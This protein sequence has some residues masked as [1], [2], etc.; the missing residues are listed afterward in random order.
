MRRYFATLLLMGLACY[1]DYSLYG[2]RAQS[3]G[4]VAC[5]PPRLNQYEDVPD[6]YTVCFQHYNAADFPPGVESA[7]KAGM[8]SWL[9]ILQSN[10]KNL[11][12][13]FTDGSEAERCSSDTGTLVVDMAPGSNWQEADTMASAHGINGSTQAKI[14]Y[15]LDHFSA[16][17][18]AWDTSGAHEFGHVLD[19]W[20][21][22]NAACQRSTVM[23]PVNQSMLSS[24]ERC[25]DKVA[26][27]TKYNADNATS[28]DY[29]PVPEGEDDCNDWY[30]VTYYFWQDENGD[31][32]DGGSSW[33][34][35]GTYCGPPPF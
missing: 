2:V 17:G 18:A 5:A 21:Q 26:I 1:M 22:E 8:E 20:H 12:L 32:P 24:E 29:E 6:S 3:S 10:G 15:N 30:L 16:S 13:N 23:W 4:C 14:T 19:L 35:L 34:F 31:W 11:H 27:S 7:I 33:D 9:P 25:A 28:Y